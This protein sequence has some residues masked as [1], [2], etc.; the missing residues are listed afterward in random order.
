MLEKWTK[1][2]ASKATDSA[3]EGVSKTLNEKVGPHIDMIQIGLV[4][5]VIALGT[6]IAKKKI[7][8]PAQAYIQ[9][10]QPPIVINN[11]YRERE[12]T[13]H[14]EQRTSKRGCYIQNG[15]IY[16][17]QKTPGQTYSKR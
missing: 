11:Y 13:K 7:T 1:R 2:F 12:D 5:G 14:Y 3:L 16:G 9:N 6:H 17:G 10:G 15:Q 4:F 8:S